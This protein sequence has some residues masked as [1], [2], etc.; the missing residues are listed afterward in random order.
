MMQDFHMTDANYAEML[1]GQGGGCAIC[2][3][4]KPN[5]TRKRFNVD[6]DHASGAVRALL[7]HD[8]NIALGAIKDD[9]AIARKMAEYVE[10]HKARPI[11]SIKF[12][13]RSARKF[14]NKR[15]VPSGNRVPNV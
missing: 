1:A 4:S 8:C 14:K 12:F 6:H 9:P 11:E 10:Y 15:L 3:R 2:G 5:G 7:C 13:W